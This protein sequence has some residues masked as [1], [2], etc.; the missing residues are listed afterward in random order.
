MILNYMNVWCFKFLA[1]ITEG[2]GRTA[3]NRYKQIHFSFN[4]FV[5]LCLRQKVTFDFKSQTNC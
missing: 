3:G 1:C 2:E 4:I 5:K